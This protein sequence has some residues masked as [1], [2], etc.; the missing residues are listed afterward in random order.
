VS[1]FKN[2][3]VNDAREMVRVDCET[4]IKHTNKMC[5]NVLILSMLQ[6]IV[7]T[8]LALNYGI[9]KRSSVIFENGIL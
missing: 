2:Q 1:L 4:Y 7:Q 9:K 5:W 8:Q 3:S 6:Q